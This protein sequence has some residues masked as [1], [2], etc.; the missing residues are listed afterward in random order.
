[1]PLRHLLSTALVAAVVSVFPAVAL[2]DGLPSG[3]LLAQM[4][5]SPMPS[6]TP[7]PM[8]SMKPAAVPTPTGVPTPTPTP[9]P[10]PHLFQPSGFADLGY[11]FLN[12]ASSLQ[13]TNGVNARVFDTEVNTPN[14]QN[15]ELIGA[16]NAG[17]L[18]GKLDFSFG[19]DAN[20]I[21][22]Y[23]QNGSNSFNITQAYLAYAF[24]PLSLQVGKYDTLAGAEVI[25]SALDYEYSRSIL[26][27]YAVP[28]THTGARLTYT[29]NP[30]ISVI[31]GVNEGWDV[32]N[33]AN[34]APTF[35]GGLAINPSPALSLTAQTYN[36]KTETGYF[37]QTG[38]Y[39]NRTL[40][41]VVGTV[42]LTPSLTLVGNYDNGNQKNA[43]LLDSTGSVILVPNGGTGGGPLYI[44]DYGTA[45][46]N[47]VAGYLNYA[48]SSLFGVTVRGE[49]FGDQGGYRTG[50]DQNWREGTVTLQYNPGPFVF[51]VE[52]RDDG[53]DHPVFTTASGYGRSS[54]STI[55]LESIVKF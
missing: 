17:N 54:L 6:A 22:S 36:G 2:A 50:F 8:A 33:M 9:T 31:A 29:V 3:N 38:I 15:L 13:F 23:G 48:I 46:W 47:G 42:K 11:N 7:A 4:S 10:V 40:Y 27:G 55:G 14:F 24:G 18:T 30:K 49:T 19:N 53:S 28:F 34:R 37:P 35:E 1:M 16:L 43:L 5:P 32:L 44:P 52:Y 45:K 21:Y 41:D 51:R 25:S 20:V 12:A 26:F 39:G